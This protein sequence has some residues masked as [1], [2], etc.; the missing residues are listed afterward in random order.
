V[1]G[2]ERFY[3]N[4][5]PAVVALQFLTPRGGSCRN[6][7]SMRSSTNVGGIASG[8]IVSGSGGARDAAVHDLKGMSSAA[9]QAEDKEKNEA[10]GSADESSEEG[11]EDDI[12]MFAGEVQAFLMDDLHFAHST[13]PADACVSLEAATTSTASATASSAPHA[14]TDPG[15]GRLHAAAAGPGASGATVATAA[16]AAGAWPWQRLAPLCAALSQPAASQRRPP[17]CALQWPVV[18][19]APYAPKKHPRGVNAR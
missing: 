16:A 15:R 3:V 1:D 14:A 7:S 18:P 5:G 2:K 9:A 4:K 13:E 8:G 12:E 19:S 10:G 11:D 17:T 6:S